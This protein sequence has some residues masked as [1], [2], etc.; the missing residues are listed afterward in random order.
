MS[1]VINTFLLVSICLFFFSYFLLRRNRN[2]NT[3]TTGSFIMWC[4]SKF[5]SVSPPVVAA[6]PAIIKILVEH[7]SL[8]GIVLL[9]WRAAW[10]R[11]P[12]HPVVHLKSTLNQ[13]SVIMLP[14]LFRPCFF[15]FLK[16]G[17]EEFQIGSL[18]WI[19]RLDCGDKWFQ[20]GCFFPC[21]S[22]PN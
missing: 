3:Q 12:Q 6:D 13:L 17:R 10:N 20:S 2:S 15:F 11:S 1:C 7:Y 19:T 16:P 8:A 14:W 4:H 5:R 9:L 21:F 22:L 18:V